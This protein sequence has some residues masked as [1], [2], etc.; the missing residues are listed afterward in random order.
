MAAR[1]KAG[2]GITTRAVG[3]IAQAAQAEAQA[4]AAAVET[5]VVTATGG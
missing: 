1:V 2:S 5:A 4:E 3:L